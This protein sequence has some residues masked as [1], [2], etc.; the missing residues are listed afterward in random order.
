MPPQSET[1]SS[2][3]QLTHAVI[4]SSRSK[5]LLAENNRRCGVATTRPKLKGETG[6][7]CF[8]PSSIWRKTDLT[9]VAFADI[10]STSTSCHLY[11]WV[12]ALEFYSGAGGR[13]LP[14]YPFLIRISPSFPRFGVCSQRLKI[15]YASLEALLR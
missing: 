11:L 2:D 13:E 8:L 15:G 6:N 10:F 5:S 12:Q 7:V 1:I 3:A 4:P 9:V 14:V